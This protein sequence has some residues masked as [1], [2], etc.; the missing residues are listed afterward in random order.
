MFFRDH[1]TVHFSTS[2]FQLKSVRRF[3]TFF[4]NSVT[5]FS[6]LHHSVRIKIPGRASAQ[7]QIKMSRCHMGIWI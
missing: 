3:F 1:N 2:L 6:F 5:D 7:I 4:K